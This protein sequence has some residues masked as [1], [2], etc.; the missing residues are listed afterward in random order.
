MV[1]SLNVT[2]RVS[3]AFSKETLELPCN[4]LPVPD[5]VPG[6]LVTDI[7]AAASILVVILLLNKIINVF[8]ALIACAMRWKESINL[9]ERVKQSRDRTLIA[10]SM[11]V[12]FSLVVVQFSL[13]SPRFMSGLNPD[14]RIAA[15]IGIFIIYLVLKTLCAFASHPKK[16][17]AKTY[18]SACMSF[19]TFFILLVFALLIAGGFAGFLEMD[20]ALAKSTML[21]ISSIFYFIYLVRLLQIFASSYSFF[22]AF[23]YLCTVELIPTGLFISTACVF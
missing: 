13:Y 20:N 5:A 12:P 9:E 16:G 3:E 14:L 11:I 4:P 8:P 1:D 6:S 7:L 17:P 2:Q 18:R 22:T 23:L 15:F 19:A 10:F 21:W